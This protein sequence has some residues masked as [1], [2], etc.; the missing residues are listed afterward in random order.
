MKESINWGIVGVGDVCEVKSAPAMSLIENSKLV[1]VMRRNGDKAKDYAVRHKVPTWYDDADALINDPEV[2]AIYIATPPGAHSEY[3]VKAAKAGKPIY[4]EKPMART[5]KEC[6]TMIDA[7]KDAGI[8]LFVAYYR[9]TLP[10]FLKVKEIIDNGT[11]GDIR[12]VHIDLVK[13]IE[14]DIV[15]SQDKNWRVDPEI[16]GGGYFYDLASHQ[17]DFLDYAL[18]PVRNATGYAANQAGVYEAEDIVTAVLNFENGVLG[19]GNWC[20][21]ADK[22]SN[23]DITT[24]V[25]SHGQ[26]SYA[27]FGT[28]SVTLEAAGKSKEVF[29]FDLPVH[30]QQPLIQTVVDELQG[31]G[32]CPST[33]ETAAR[34]NLVMESI[35]KT[36]L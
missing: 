34:T 30:V 29:S 11:I 15:A 26:L 32:Y 16:A 24:I 20:F 7:C 23:R 17:L 18:G 27:S 31:K 1:A 3:A 4:V 36:Q 5:Y 13:S 21:T 25:G 33:G 2:N 28:P 19:T 9:R 6:I 22:T 8:P 35:L 14:P 10:H 12:F